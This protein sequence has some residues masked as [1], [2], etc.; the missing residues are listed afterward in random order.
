MQNK[1]QHV[2]RRDRSPLLR[3]TVALAAVIIA[4]L[5][6]RLLDPWL[7]ELF[8]FAVLFFAVLAVAWYG[9]FGPAI[10]ASLLGAIA[11]AAFLLPPRG[12]AAV[13]GTENQLGLAL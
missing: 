7:G 6:R 12:T 5:A 1:K 4:T 13:L 9:G 10:A 3:Y 2:R 8:P 11:S